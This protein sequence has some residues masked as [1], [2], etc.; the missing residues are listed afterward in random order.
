MTAEMR[1][2]TKARQDG[3]PAASRPAGSLV[4]SITALVFFVVLCS[5]LA[6][7]QF[8]VAATTL[9]QGPEALAAYISSW[10]LGISIAAIPVHL[11]LGRFLLR[12]DRLPAALLVA[13]AV[14]L[15][16]GGAMILLPGISAALAL[17]ATDGAFRHSFHE[18]V[19]EGCLLALP[20]PVRVQARLIADTLVDRGAQ[21]VASGLLWTLTDGLGLGERGLAAV[22]AFVALAWFV[23]AIHLGTHVARSLMPR[24]S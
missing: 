16:V 2:E 15:A 12:Q 11:V 8:A 21:A 23:T 24:S 6:E 17:K 3:S 1:A 19:L 5:T 14:M 7:F 9:R 4:R 18:A 13:P 22:T 10:Q 20:E